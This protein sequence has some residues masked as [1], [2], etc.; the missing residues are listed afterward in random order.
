MN[1]FTTCAV[2][3][4]TLLIALPR[5]YH[6]SP[7]GQRA[8]LPRLGALIGRP[9]CG[10]WVWATA[11]DF[12]SS[13][14]SLCDQFSENQTMS[15]LSTVIQC[16][17]GFAPGVEGILKSSTRPVSGSSF[18]IQDVRWLVNQIL[19]FESATVSCGAV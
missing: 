13:R 11:P 8:R 16:C 12:G 15:S 18:E 17:P 4:S 14:P 9:K 1:L 6:M 5:A 19:P 3:G 7:Y 2:L 10:N